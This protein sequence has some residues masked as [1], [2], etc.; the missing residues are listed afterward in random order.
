M[1]R[2]MTPVPIQPMRVVDGEMGSWGGPLML[3]IDRRWRLSLVVVG[4]MKR[5]G[6]RSDERRTNINPRG[7]RAGRSALPLVLST[8]S[9]GR[10]L[11]M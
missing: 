11:F 4:M 5:V 7:R 1:E 9:S 2:P 6:R 3:D 8:Q 10:C